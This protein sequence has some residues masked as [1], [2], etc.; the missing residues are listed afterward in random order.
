MKQGQLL[1]SCIFPYSFSAFNVTD[2]CSYLYYAHPSAYFGFV[3]LSPVSYSGSLHYWLN[4]LLYLNI[5]FR[6]F[7]DN[8][9]NQDLSASGGSPIHFQTLMVRVKPKQLP[10][11]FDSICLFCSLEYYWM[12]FSSLYLQPLF[13]FFP[14]F[15]AKQL[16]GAFYLS[17]HFLVFTSL[18]S[19]QK[20]HGLL[21]FVTAMAQAEITALSPSA[22]DNF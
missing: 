8:S 9:D 22:A 16:I 2:F 14:P 13:H 5:T 10:S 3:F 11:S 15:R 6:V 19:K 7:F 20:Y 17:L 18:H 21:Y 4:T 12:C 1:V